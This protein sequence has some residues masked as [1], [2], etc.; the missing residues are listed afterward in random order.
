MNSI[1]TNQWYAEREK[2]AADEVKRVIHTAAMLIRREIRYRVYNR[3]VF[4]SAEQSAWGNREI[5]PDRLRLLIYGIL[6]PAKP[7]SDDK[8][9]GRKSVTIQHAIISAVRPRSFVSPLHIGLGIHLHRK[10]GPRV[11]IDM[12]SNIRLCASYSEVTNYEAPLTTNAQFTVDKGAY[13]QFVFDNADY[14]VSTLDGHRT[15]Y[16]M[17]GIKCVTPA[18][19]VHVDAPVPRTGSCNAVA[20]GSHRLTEVRIY[21]QPMASLY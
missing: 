5:V 12:L 16:A 8:K 17:G 6:K 7:D 11:L 4:P 3:E 20:V 9:H 15:F 21:H 19:K 1:L 18:D 10:Y 14:N 2:N 13:I